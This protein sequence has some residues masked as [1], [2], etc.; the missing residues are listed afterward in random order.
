M[1]TYTNNLLQNNGFAFVLE[2]I[3]QTVFRVTATSVPAINVPPAPAGYPGSSQDFPGT[4]TEFEDITLEFLVDENLENYEE[5]YRW[6]VKQRFAENQVPK[7]DLDVSYFS[8]GVLTTMTNSSNPNRKFKF[9][10]MF[11]YA[12]GQLSFDT[13]VTSPSPVTCIATF[14]YSYFELMPIGGVD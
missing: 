13:S 8:D 6:I 12:L 3:P 14:K 9:K 7:S 2:R 10:S 11:P 5:I 1:Q 4:F